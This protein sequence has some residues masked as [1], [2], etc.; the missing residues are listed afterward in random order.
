MFI[1]KG[2]VWNGK[3]NNSDNVMVKIYNDRLPLGN[4]TKL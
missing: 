2:Y 4:N 3:F 1:D